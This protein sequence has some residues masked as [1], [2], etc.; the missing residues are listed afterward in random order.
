MVQSAANLAG[1]FF[2]RVPMRIEENLILQKD[3]SALAPA[4][5]K[6]YFHFL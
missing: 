5:V 3:G 1:I 2:T 6:I 4:L